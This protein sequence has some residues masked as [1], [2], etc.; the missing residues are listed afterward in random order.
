MIRAIAAVDV[1]LGLATDDGIPWSIPADVEHFRNTTSSSSVLMGYA[2][3]AEFESPMP[4]RTNYVATRRAPSL[5]DGFL[6]VSDLGSFLSDGAAGDL[7][8]IGGAALYAA[9]IQ[10]AHEL[11][12]T[13]VDGDFNC[14][15]FFPAF[16]PTFALATDVAVPSMDGTP[17]IRFQTWERRH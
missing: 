1:R 2:T 7:W 13:R 16:E 6:P 8:I 14:T 9:T 12:L 17:D 15:K 10:W 3:Y 4:G 11:N 5:R